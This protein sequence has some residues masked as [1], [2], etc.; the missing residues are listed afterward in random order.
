MFDM[1]GK[2]MDQTMTVPTRK[3]TKE[4]FLGMSD[5]EYERELYAQSLSGK[6]KF[7]EM[8]DYEQKRFMDMLMKSKNAAAAESGKAQAMQLGLSQSQPQNVMGLQGLMQMAMKGS[9]V[10]P[11]RKF[12]LMGN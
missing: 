4:D 3:Q 7:K 8:E 5:D 12:G 11:K 2:G 6:I 9:G 10:Q 1:L